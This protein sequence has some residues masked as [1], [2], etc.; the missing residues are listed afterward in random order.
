MKKI[1]T[2][3]LIFTFS[4]SYS[5]EKIKLVEYTSSKCEEIYFENINKVNSRII[6]KELIND[7]LNISV[8]TTTS[9]DNTE[10]G[11]IEVKND[12]LNL[13][14]HT[15]RDFIEPITKIIVKNDSI[16]V[17]EKATHIEEITECECVYKLNYLI[18]NIELEKFIVTLNSKIIEESEHQF[19]I[20]RDKATFEIVKGDTINLIDIYGLKQKLHI[21]YR[22]D[23]K[24]ISKLYF[25]DGEKISGLARVFYDFFGFDKA[26]TYIEKGK[27]TKRKYYNKGKLIKTCDTMGGFEED[28]KCVY[29]K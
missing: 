7:I 21:K 29:Q 24:L 6:N 5:Q 15:K 10:I 3:L 28:T 9:C 18:K 17:I 27:F 16:Q 25:K 1:F 23:G 19:K 12:T 22:K 2:L 14:H 4:S 13:I 8:L 20:K 11:E 26:E